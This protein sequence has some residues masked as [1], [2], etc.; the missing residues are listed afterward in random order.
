MTIG[1]GRTTGS[2]PEQACGTRDNGAWF[3]WNA[4]VLFSEPRCTVDASGRRRPRAQPLGVASWGEAELAVVLATEL[5]SAVVSDAVAD[6]RD[7]VDPGHQHQARLLEADLLLEIDRAEPGDSVE[8][9]V[10]GR[11]AH[12]AGSRQ[13][14]DPERLAVVR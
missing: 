1:R 4:Q 11:C 9:A 14:L 12:A 10:E 2:R 7:V 3:A 13:F 8:A 6:R 5:R